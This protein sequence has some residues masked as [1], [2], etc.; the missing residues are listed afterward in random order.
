METDKIAAQPIN[1]AHANNFTM[2]F[3]DI[4]IYN[5]FETGFKH[6]VIFLSSLKNIFIDRSQSLV[7]I[8]S[9]RWA[10]KLTTYS[11]GWYVM[12]FPC[13]KCTVKHTT[14][15]FKSK[16]PYVTVQLVMTCTPLDAVKCDTG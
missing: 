6:F 4:Y 15:C 16:G 13:Y 10:D 5:N 8:S 1:L 11:Y 3:V 14:L 7:Y 12:I 2:G 9:S